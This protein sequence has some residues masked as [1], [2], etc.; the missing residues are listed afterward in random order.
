M[1]ALSQMGVLDTDPRAGCH[2][3]KMTTEIR[4]LLLQV[5]ACQAPPATWELGRGRELLLP[6]HGTNTC[7]HLHSG[8]AEVGDSKFVIS[9][10]LGHAVMAA[11]AD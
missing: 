8:F 3:V 4:V 2:H 5:K 1:G 10:I 7:Q 9:A 6:S 11:Q